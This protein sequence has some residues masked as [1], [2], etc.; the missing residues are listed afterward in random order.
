MGL[1]SI[2]GHV[3]GPQDIEENVILSNYNKENS[4]ILNEE[5]TNQ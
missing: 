5:D 3:A 2:S 1:P 4:C